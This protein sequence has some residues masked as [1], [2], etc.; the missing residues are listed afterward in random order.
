MSNL[1]KHSEQPFVFPQGVIGQEHTQASL[2]SMLDE[3]N[4]VVSESYMV[5]QIGPAE[6]HAAL[7]DSEQVRGLL[8]ARAEKALRGS[9][10]SRTVG[11]AVNRSRQ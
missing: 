6:A 1:D 2:G 5:G 8:A 10:W 4:M 9:L 3:R 7:D 11:R